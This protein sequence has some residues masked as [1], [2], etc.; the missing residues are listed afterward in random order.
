MK[1]SKSHNMS[2]YRQLIGSN[3]EFVINGF[4]VLFLSLLFSKSLNNN[5][6]H[7]NYFFC[8]PSQYRDVIMMYCE[9]VHFC[10]HKSMM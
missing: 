7:S 9:G 6:L 1:L 5:N 10:P 2:I 4:I 3:G 8:S